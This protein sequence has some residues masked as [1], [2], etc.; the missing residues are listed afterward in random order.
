VVQKITRRETGLLKQK[1]G[2]IG[3]N[4]GDTIPASVA[5]LILLLTLPILL[6]AAWSANA[7]ANS[8]REK[9]EKAAERNLR[10]AV[11]AINRYVHSARNMLTA[12]ASSPPLQTGDLEG[13]YRQAVQVSGE[14]GVHISLRDLRRNELVIHTAYPPHA[15]ER[16]LPSP[17]AERT[18]QNVVKSLAPQ[19]S[20]V[21]MGQLQKAPVVMIMVPVNRPAAPFYALTMVQ[22][23]E[24]IANILRDLDRDSGW[25]TSVIDR[26]GLTVAHS[27]RHNEFAGKATTGFPTPSDHSLPFVGELAGTLPD[28]TS[29]TYFY[30]RSVMTGW[31]VTIAVPDRVLKKPGDLALGGLASASVVILLIA[32]FTGHKLTRRFSAKLGALQTA[33]IVEQGL[34]EDVFQTFS[35]TALRCVAAT[36]RVGN[37]FFVSASA[38]TMFGYDHDALIGQ[39][40]DKLTPGL[41]EWLRKDEAS[42][43]EEDTTGIRRDGT[44]L[45][46]KVRVH[47]IRME[48]SAL[49]IVVFVDQL[50]QEHTKHRLHAILGERDN[51]R[52]RLMQAQERERER[53]AR[54]LHDQ[55]GQIIAGAMMDLKGLESLVDDSGRDRIRK[56]HEQLGTM[57]QTL[58]RIA[59]ELRPASIKD[60]GLIDTLA[61]YVA[62]WSEHFG[63]ATEFYCANNKVDHLSDEVSTAIYR[64]IQE[65]LTNIAKH[66]TGAILVTVIIDFDGPDLRLTIE[67][68]GCGFDLASLANSRAKHRRLGLDGIRERLWLIGGNIEIESSVGVGTGLFVSIPLERERMV[69]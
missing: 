22:R 11:L 50:A 8:E 1:Q 19:V 27:T 24:S 26:E 2:T 7:W 53:L 41:T 39:S 65:G 37:I 43:Q 62:E 23:T 25:T 67:D 64:I 15:T 48:T 14:L 44:T 28:G 45:R 30:Q 52:R 33:T 49:N 9:I 18:S 6:F 55:T 10:N 46:L 61:D 66:A 40:I 36:D 54:D 68:N 63:I 12:L 20:G 32:G 35:K 4:K 60:V 57:G 59:Q 21:F 17:V 47:T 3:A 16:P 42:G 69:A 38:G 31:I 58:H 51:L 56:L 5:V 29:A 13:F 34:N